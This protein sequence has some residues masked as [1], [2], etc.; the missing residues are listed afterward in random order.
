MYR[1]IILLRMLTDDSNTSQLLSNS[2]VTVMVPTNNLANTVLTARHRPIPHMARVRHMAILGK[3][4]PLLGP[5]DN[6]SQAL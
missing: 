5:K 4:T 1:S 3:H 2:R 6:N